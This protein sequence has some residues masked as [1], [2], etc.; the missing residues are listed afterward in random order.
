MK[1]TMKFALVIGLLWFAY[2]CFQGA[3]SGVQS[4][5]AAAQNEQTSLDHAG[6]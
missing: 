4:V 3:N 1:K 2:H 5:K 6:E